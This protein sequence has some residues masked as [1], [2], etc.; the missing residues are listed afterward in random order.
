MIAALKA[1]SSPRMRSPLVQECGEA[2]EELARYKE[3]NEKADELARHGSRE[4]CHGPEPYLGITRRQ[5]TVAFNEWAESALGEHWRLSR[6]CRQAREFVSGPNRSRV[7]WL[8]GHGRNTLNR[9]IGVF[10]GHCRLRRHLSLMG[11]E[12]NPNCPW[13]G[14][15]RRN[16]FSFPGTV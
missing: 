11:V 1:L 12:D 3:E 7:A 13:C 15:G 5:V 8:L 14:G 4:Q 16:G 10:T 9:L 6:G 2:L